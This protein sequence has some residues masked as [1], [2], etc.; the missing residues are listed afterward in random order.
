[1]SEPKGPTI[2]YDL[3]VPM[4]DGVK[5]SANVFLPPGRGRF[6][7]IMNRTPYVKDSGRKERLRRL[8]ASFARSGY[9]VVHM[10]VRGR[11]NSG[12]T[13]TPN[14]Q[15]A[16]DGFDSFAWAGTAP[17]SN[18]K[19]GTFGPSYEGWDQLIPM[20]L[21][22]RY[23]R[24]AFVMCAPSLHPFRDCAGYAFGAPMAI[25]SMWRLF[26]TGRT[27]KE[28]IYDE[29]FDWALALN[30]RPLKDT[31]SK[32]GVVDAPE[33]PLASHPTY[34]EYWKSFWSDD[35]VERWNVPSYFVTG[36]FDDSIRGALEYFPMLTKAHP[37]LEFRKRHKLLIG[38]WYHALSAPFEPSSKVGEIDYGPS[39]VV[40]LGQEALRWFD[41][42]LKGVQNG[43]MDEPPTRLF[44]MGANRWMRPSEF[45]LPEARERVYY[46]SATG[47]SN[48][49]E[50]SGVLSAE[51]RRD[52]GRD[53]SSF[54][55][56]PR[57]PAP[58]PF[59]KKNFQNGT[60]EDLRAIQ[61]RRD[62]L[63][64][65]SDPLASP[66]NAVGMLSARLFVSTSAV[67]T[68][69]VARLSDVHP[70]GYA[71]RLNHGILRL[72]YREGFEKAVPVTPGAVMEITV[73]MAA[74]GQR[75]QKGHRVRLDV[76]SSAFPV[77]SPNL[78]TGEGIWD[79]AKP[80]R[81]TQ[82][83]FHSDRY[84]SRLIVQEVRRVPR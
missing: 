57:D 23:H 17:W 74:T 66:L 53:H 2:A 43:V 10:D 22:S 80:V 3:E 7:V 76:T 1:M 47:P 56:D 48:T 39:S 61:G 9:A 71:E 13:F 52:G 18:G 28:E 37:D 62:V 15:E 79:E 35:M 75:F 6:P 29:D 14:V 16:E 78:N 40:D 30:V 82:K 77:Y 49:L 36:W 72:R 32:L 24:A 38:P 31:L 55:Y 60:N 19:I 46:L 41:Y 84:P 54:D 26:I 83:V 27:L 67:D 11:G 64:F 58:A 59:W 21:R 70:G 12:G 51:P 73:D 5:L 69:F 81:A 8:S 25:M 63:V 20:R 65:T 68:D 50:G 42:W 33:N 34:D 44:L 45:P 4:R